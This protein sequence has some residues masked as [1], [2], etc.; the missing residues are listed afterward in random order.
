MYLK[1]LQLVGFKSFA[2][3]TALEF[4]PGVTAIVGPNGCGKSNVSDAIRW[5]L[6]EQ[7]AKA[8]R[9]G[10][11]ADVIFNGTDS[12]KPIGMAEVSLTIGDITPDQLRAAGVSL[13]Y[14]EVTVSRRVFRDGHGEYFINKTP[15]RLKDVQ[16]LFMDTG[17]GRS[18]YS[19]MAQGQ[20]DQIL[21]AHPD[22]RRAIFEEAAGI[23]KFKSQKKE[24]L[25]KLEHTEANLVR[26]ADIIRE[27]KRQIGSLQRQAGKAKRYR[28]LHEQLKMLETKLARHQ[29]DELIEQIKVHQAQADAFAAELAE[30]MRRTETGESELTKTRRS[31]EELEQ[32][33]N[34]VVH[35]GMEI[36]GATEK[37]TNRIQFN[38][39][40]I[41]ELAAQN[42]RATADIAA[43]EE[44][45]VVQ[46]QHL[47]QIAQQLQQAGDAVAQQEARVSEG[48]AAQNKADAD[49]ELQEQE[50]DQVKNQS[51]ELESKS[52]HLRN[53][54]SSL[55]TAQRNATIRLE[56]LTAE[57]TDL[58]EQRIQYAQKVESFRVEIEQQR[59]QI[60]AARAALQ[61]RKRQLEQVS[62]ELLTI[63]VQVLDKSSALE[64]ASSKLRIFQQLEAENEGISDGGKALLQR[65]NEF[66]VIGSLAQ[67]LQ[68]P[69]EFTVAIEAALGQSL[70]AILVRDVE[71]AKQIVGILRNQQIGRAAVLLANWSSPAISRPPAPEWSLGWAADKVQCADEF[72]PL[73]ERL[74]GQALLVSDVGVALDHPSS[75]FDMVTRDGEWISRVGLVVGGVTI[76]GPLVRKNQI[77]ECRMTVAELKSATDAL[78]HR[79]SELDAQRASL[80][81]EVS[82]QTTALHKLEM[83][84]ASKEGQLRVIE[85]ESQDVVLKVETVDFELNSLSSQ[86]GAQSGRRQAI[87]DQIAANTKRQAELHAQLSQSEQR[88]AQLEDERRQLSDTLTEA[89]IGLA[90]QQQRHANLLGQKAPA[91]AR[92]TEL[93]DAIAARQAEIASNE[94]RAIQLRSEIAKSETEL[95]R[96]KT[97]R[98]EV[99]RI[100]SERQAR[101]QEINALIVQQEEQIRSLH[102]QS[103]ETQQRKN[104]L[105]I[106]L[107]ELR[108]TINHLKDRIQQ[109][110]QVNIE[111]IRGEGFIITIADTGKPEIHEV[112]PGEAQQA[113]IN[114]TNWDEVAQQV[115]EMQSRLDAMGPV[116][117]GAVEEFEELEQRHKFLTEQQDDLVKA[118]EQLLEVLAKINTTT[119]QMF[120]ETFEKIRVNFQEMFG[121]L[122][123]GGKANLLLVDEGDV[124]ESGIEIVARPPGKQLQSISLLSGGERTMTAVA[125]LFSIYMVKPSP[126]CVLDELDAPLDESNIN[127]FIK[128]LQRFRQQSQF[129]II[130]H[131]KRTIAMGDALYG[132]TMEEHGIS[133][134]VS[135]KFRKQLDSAPT[136][137]AAL[138]TKALA[139]ESPVVNES[140]DE[141]ATD[142]HV[143][144]THV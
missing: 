70:Q 9:G 82:E 37:H 44:K 66:G 125:L 143:A 105:D 42:Q 101:R 2:E 73:V 29:Y 1:N 135:V 130:T 132:V 106:K 63:G 58:A 41:N 119:K 35:R 46:Q 116:N 65:A 19:M 11:M 72:R 134:L 74:L 87:L 126:F 12:R 50:A 22:D 102:K 77:A 32:Q 107:S 47:A 61:E 120:T 112:T 6:G 16:Q 142:A 60:E 141:M 76:Q 91:E 115:A 118:K 97:E 98:D 128:I 109:K 13:E 89:K 56:R 28:E 54:L 93:N 33:T 140:T 48:V 26:L 78:T 57:K 24:A 30:A 94:Q 117:L 137:D 40:R 75:D 64:G 129:I 136:A 85:G 27:V 52:A 21:S 45:I 68:V 43:A 123:G 59:S 108:M 131:N 18:S 39:E 36:Q 90:T 3:K 4:L 111:D 139:G 133:K 122:F 114:A 138:E 71:S 104:E 121:E 20:I 10:E 92:V 84:H 88:L 62:S 86:G 124:L 81:R 5:V 79:K 25:R 51:I 83:A 15:V 103:S 95:V 14:N 127:R 99:D 23:T 49:I 31:L 34:E 17:V 7:S 8:L 100:L 96:L 55:D 69:G 80:D 113:G 38:N 144:T 53:D 67:A 110:Y